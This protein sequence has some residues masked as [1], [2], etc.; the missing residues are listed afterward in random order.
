MWAA[1][2][3]TAAAALHK[4][5]RERGVETKFRLSTKFRIEKQLKCFKFNSKNKLGRMLVKIAIFWR[6]IKL[7]LSKP[8]SSLHDMRRRVRDSCVI[9][10]RG[11]MQREGARTHILSFFC[12]YF[13]RVSCFAFMFGFWQKIRRRVKLQNP[14]PL[15]PLPIFF[16][17]DGG[18]PCISRKYW[19]K[20]IF[21]QYFSDL[22]AMDQG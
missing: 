21:Q 6:Q 4:K 5:E 19:W 11:E 14:P 1:A 3:E 13:S 8:K 2:S 22:W 18:F 10:K 9:E 15:P 17:P 7:F 12:F 20:G 16:L